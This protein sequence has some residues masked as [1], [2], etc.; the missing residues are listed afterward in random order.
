[1][2]KLGALWLDGGAWQGMQ[3]IPA[4]WLAIATT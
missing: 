1:M 3:L 2:I 4:D